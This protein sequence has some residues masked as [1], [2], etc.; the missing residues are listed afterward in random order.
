VRLDRDAARELAEEL[1]PPLQFAPYAEGFEP[2]VEALVEGRSDAQVGR[3]VRA[4]AAAVW[5]DALRADTATALDGFENY[6]RDTLARL[7]A[8][9]AELTR[10]PADNRLAMAL[11][12]RLCTDHL[13]TVAALGARFDELEAEMQFAEPEE[14]REVALR[15]A[16]EIGVSGISD[17]ERYSATASFVAKPPP[18]GPSGRTLIEQSTRALARSLATDDRRRSTRQELA[19][20]A[21]EARDEIPL[22][23]EAI[24][25]LLGEPLSEDAGEDDVWVSALF[26][27]GAVESP[28]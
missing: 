25:D 23:A 11:V 13:E 18:E 1:V 9:R 10:P 27:A 26:G 2:V 24:D 5:D 4:A 19:F 20:L 3:R 8:A 16:A 14:R 6:L 7:D 15:A 12:E 21:E 28:R 17:E 22:L